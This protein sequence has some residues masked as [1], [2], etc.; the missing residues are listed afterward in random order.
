MFW[1]SSERFVQAALG[2]FFHA[3]L[4]AVWSMFISCHRQLFFE[5]RTLYEMMW[6][7]T[8]EPDRPQMT[9]WRMRIV[10]WKPKATNKPRYYTYCFSTA[11]VV[12]LKRLGVTLCVYCLSGASYSIFIQY[13]L[14]LLIS[15]FSVGRTF[16]T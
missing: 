6:K 5:N 4:Q 2:Y 10:C 7:Y 11:T 15:I 14:K 8:E 9:I 12:A 13:S 3:S 1:T 16:E